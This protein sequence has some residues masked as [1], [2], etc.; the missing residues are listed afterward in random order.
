M[1]GNDRELL[2]AL[3]SLTAIS[4]L[5]VSTLYLHGDGRCFDSP[6]FLDS[7]FEGCFN[8]QLQSTD[9]S[10]EALCQIVSSRLSTY[11]DDDDDGKVSGA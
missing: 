1:H 7:L 3:C 6:C 5:D 2:G 11:D 8:S 10:G 4:H 9:L